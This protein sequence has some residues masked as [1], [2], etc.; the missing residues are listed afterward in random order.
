MAMWKHNP[1]TSVT[2]TVCAMW[3]V[4]DWFE[5]QTCCQP[6][7]SCQP[8]NQPLR[9][10]I[11]HPTTPRIPCTTPCFHYPERPPPQTHPIPSFPSPSNPSHTIPPPPPPPPAP[12]SHPTATTTTTTTPSIP[13]PPPPQQRTCLCHE[14]M[15]GPLEGEEAPAAARA[16]SSIPQLLLMR[17]RHP[18]FI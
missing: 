14:A 16:A 1:A 11:S 2:A 8:S 3:C 12:Q 10:I 4:V 17:R 6:P 15:Q 7:L 5:C 9:S 13:P 18:V